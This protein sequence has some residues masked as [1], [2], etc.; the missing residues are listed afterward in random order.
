MIFRERLLVLGGGG[1]VGLAAIQLAVSI[2]CRVSTTCGCKSFD[3]VISAGAE[4]AINYEAEVILLYKTLM[5]NYHYL[6]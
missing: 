4:Q 6:F 2:G 3:Q 5:S 1:A